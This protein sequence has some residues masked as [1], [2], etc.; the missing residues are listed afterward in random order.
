MDKLLVGD[1]VLY[2]GSHGL[3]V[4]QEATIVAMDVTENPFEKYG[5]T[6]EE[7]DWD[8][9]EA[10]RVVFSVATEQGEKWGYSNQIKPFQE[11]LSI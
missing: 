6:V 10:N 7:V 11:E 2:S 4:Y 9:V 5:T 3:E 1:K 8:L